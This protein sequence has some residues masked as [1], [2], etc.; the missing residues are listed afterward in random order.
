MTFG[1]SVTILPHSLPS[2]EVSDGFF[3]KLI[4]V[5]GGTF[6]SSV[7]TFEI[8]LEPLGF[9]NLPKE[10]VPE[11]DL[12][13]DVAHSCD[14]RLPIVEESGQVILYKRNLKKVFDAI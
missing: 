1:N 9:S 10:D 3:Q 7:I 14:N 12:V 5:F 11:G 2:E 8:K 4:G 13:R 6:F